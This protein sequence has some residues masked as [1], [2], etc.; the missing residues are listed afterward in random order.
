MPITESSEESKPD[1]ACPGHDSSCCA[2]GA[3]GVGRCAVG[4][5]GDLV[6]Q[7]VPAADAVEADQ[8]ERQQRRDD[9]EELQHLVVDRGAQPAEGDVGQHDHAGDDQRD[10]DRPAEQ[11]VHDAGEQRE[12]HAGDQQLGDREADR[13]DQVGA[14][15][16]AAEHELGDRAH[17]RAVVERHHHHAE[18]Q[19]G[20]DG[21]DPEVVHRREADL[22]TVGRHAHDL[23]RAEV[24]GD[25]RQAGD[26]G[27][28]RA[29]GQEEVDRVRHR[30][31]CHDADAEDEG[32]VD[33][34]QQVVEPGCIDQGV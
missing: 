15:A 27:G 31:A 14:G 6:G 18:E 30:A 33:R 13:V 16:E 3:T 9:H 2:A 5:R 24:R 10:P 32:E 12:V 23:D 29:P 21:T 26:P 11:G 17:L 25:E 1:S 22:G 19:H 34:H 4:G 28:Q 8:G 7:P 20:G